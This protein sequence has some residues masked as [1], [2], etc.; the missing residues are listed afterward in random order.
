[1]KKN[2]KTVRPEC[3]AQQNVSKDTNGISKILLLFSL[4]AAS[5]L[6]TAQNEENYSYEYSQDCTEDLNSD[7]IALRRAFGAKYWDQR[8]ARHCVPDCPA[9]FS[10]KHCDY[11]RYKNSRYRYN[12]S[13]GYKNYWRY[14]RWYY[15]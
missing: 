12:E 5:S 1:M 11:W 4:L 13:R 9:G 6:I 7:E 2:T 14:P 3:F 8:E 15:F 10:E